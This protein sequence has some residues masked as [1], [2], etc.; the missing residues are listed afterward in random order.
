[1]MN[2]ER[3][4]EAGGVRL[5]KKAVARVFK[6]QASSLKPQAILIVHRSSFI[7]HPFLL[8]IILC[9]GT[10]AAATEPAV[11][12]FKKTAEVPGP[13]ITVAQVADVSG[14]QAGT[15]AALDLGEVPWPGTKRLI[16]ATVVKIKL[17]REGFDLKNTSFSGD[18][19]TVST[20]TV[21]IPGSEILDAAR[22]ALLER[23]AWP[24]E[25]VQ[26]E[27]ESQPGDQ[28]VA[29]GTARPTLE[30]SMAGDVAPGGKTRVTVTGSTDGKPIFRTTVPFVVHAFETILV[31]RRDIS[32]GE[33]FSE[34]NIIGR[35][36]DVSTLSPGNLFN[37]SAA[38]AGKK[39]ARAIRAGM[40]VTRQTVVIPPTVKRGNVVQIVYKTPFLSL[41]AAA[42]AQEDG[43]PGKMIRLV[44]VDSGREVIGEV[45]PN[46]QVRVGPEL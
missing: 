42:V 23:L 16:D 19:C 14:P 27:A 25:N 24:P 43:S 34:E 28:L 32:H 13:S 31:A 35:R 39:A 10:W 3:R 30:A 9:V 6:P 44:N 2:D 15:I 18:G 7:I 45:L 22:K 41:A 26:A 46:G 29:A 17:Y 1:M 8:L 4:L 5:E 33:T 38:L 11:I 21:T 12:A 20:Q 37:D 36:L 40:P